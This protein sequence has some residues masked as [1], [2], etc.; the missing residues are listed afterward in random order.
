MALVDA[1]RDA[2]DV[3]ARVVSA[4]MNI[5]YCGVPLFVMLSGALLL[6]KDEPMKVFFKKRLSRVLIPFLVWSVI[7]GAILYLQG[8]GR[9]IVGYTLYELKSVA[10]T[11]VHGIY[12]YVYMI[13]GLYCLTPVLRHI[14]HSGNEARG[15]GI[16]LYL[17]VLCLVTAVLGDAIP[18]LQVL[19][20]W[21]SKN[22]IMLFYFMAG[23]L[24]SQAVRIY[25]DQINY[26]KVFCI[27]LPVLYAI[28]VIASFYGVEVPGFTVLLSVSL[29]G[30]L[31]TIP[32][33]V[34]NA[35]KTSQLVQSVS[36]YSYGIYLSHFML[37]SALVKLSFI[38]SIPL[39]VEPL[40]MA[41]IVLVVD[42]GLMYLM[43]KMKI[44]KYVF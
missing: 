11:G 26:K 6:G 37:I 9:S 29:F 22:L 25:Y 12:W 5:I 18:E 10:T 41:T 14:I 32:V 7:V 36:K 42:V 28:S 44:G 13:I 40:L 17:S 20:H 24:V 31:M 33:T 23:Y 35:T 19:S 1:A 3:T 30:V 21:V 15:G 4:L 2:G 39:W 43:D 8:G 16:L 34:G 38:S 27:S